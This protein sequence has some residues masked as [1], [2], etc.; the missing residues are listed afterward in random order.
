VHFDSKSSQLLAFIN[1]QEYYFSV[2]QL[3]TNPRNYDLFW[4][5]YTSGAKT[6]IVT[7]YSTFVATYFSSSVYDAG[8]FTTILVDPEGNMMSILVD[9]TTNQITKNQPPYMLQSLA[10]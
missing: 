4:I 2:L 3:L 7:A 10:V 5:D 8:L 6:H 1:N 9:V